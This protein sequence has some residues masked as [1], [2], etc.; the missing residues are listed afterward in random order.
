MN[1]DFIWRSC[2]RTT[3]LNNAFISCSSRSHY[4]FGFRLW[5]C[6]VEH[7]DTVTGKGR[8][9]DADSIRLASVTCQTPQRE[10]DRGL[11][12]SSSVGQSDWG[13]LVRRLSVMLVDKGKGKELTFDTT[14]IDLSDGIVIYGCHFEYGVCRTLNTAPHHWQR[15]TWLAAGAGASGLSLGQVCSG[16][17]TCWCVI[18]ATAVI[19]LR[20]AFVS[21][22]LIGVVGVKTQDS[23]MVLSYGTI[24]YGFSHI[25]FSTWIWLLHIARLGHGWSKPPLFKM[26]S[27]LLDRYD[28]HYVCF[29]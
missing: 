24:D 12:I 11:R 16:A 3:P 17:Q 13:I 25:N 18:G 8:P 7:N 20:Q 6:V 10:M 19:S 4:F 14:R 1:Y 26:N 15:T 21:R 2:S 23:G 5:R 9:S 27:G 28:N 22:C 29:S